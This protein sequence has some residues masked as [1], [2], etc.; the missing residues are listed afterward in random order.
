MKIA[1]RILQA[2]VAASFSL[3]IPTS[4]VAHEMTSENVQDDKQATAGHAKPPKQRTV[5]ASL[6]PVGAAGPDGSGSHS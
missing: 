6:P 2:V 5:L 3:A 4:V 1:T